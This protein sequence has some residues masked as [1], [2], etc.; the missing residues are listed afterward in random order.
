MDKKFARHAWGARRL[1]AT[2]SATV[3]RTRTAGALVVTLAVVA[4]AGFLLLGRGEPAP[5]AFH[6]PAHPTGIAVT[7]HEVWVAAP[8]S[9]VLSVLDTR[10]GRRI[11]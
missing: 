11:G 2:Q 5:A 10:S 8:Q 4:A 1:G 9:G 6:V 7:G 3:P